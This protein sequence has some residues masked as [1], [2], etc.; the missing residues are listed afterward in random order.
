[1][2]QD[3][4]TISCDSKSLRSRPPTNIGATE[5]LIGA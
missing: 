5:T 3:S 4:S 2:A 1:M